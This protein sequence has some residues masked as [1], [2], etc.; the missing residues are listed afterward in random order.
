VYSR[1]GQANERVAELEAAKKINDADASKN[2]GLG[3]HPEIMF[4]LGSTYAVLNPPRKTEAIQMLKRFSATACKGAS[5]AT[6][7]K[8][9]CEQSQAL[10]AKLGG[11]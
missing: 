7:Y 11:S 6:K 10:I 9:P 5:A 8:D 4:N 1:K 3:D 2:G